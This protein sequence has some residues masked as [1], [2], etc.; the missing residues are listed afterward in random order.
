[1]L[2]SPPPDSRLFRLK[3]VSTMPIN[4][5]NKAR[6]HKSERNLLSAFCFFNVD[7]V[8]CTD[9]FSLDGRRGVQCEVKKALRKVVTL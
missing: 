2:P 1:M 5:T 3:S 8:D 7:C 4:Q 9:V 6:Q